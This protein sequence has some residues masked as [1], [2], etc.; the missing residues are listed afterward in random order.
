MG[1]S[2]MAIQTPAGNGLVGEI[3]VDGRSR[4]ELPYLWFKRQKKKADFQVKSFLWT[5]DTENL[6]FL[7]CLKQS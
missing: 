7:Q 3:I 5:T 6:R 4:D 1:L 2:V